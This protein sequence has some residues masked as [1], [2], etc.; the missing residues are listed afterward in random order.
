MQAASTRIATELR[1]RITAGELSPG[2]RVPST[3]QIVTDWGVAMATASK[4]LAILRQDGLVEAL[5]GFGTV[6]AGKRAAPGRSGPGDLT[7]ERIVRAA[8]LIADLEGLGA[9]SMRRV[10]TELSVATMSLYRHIAN[11]DKL[12]E[13]MADTIFSDHPLPARPRG[14]WRAQLESVMRL[15]WSLYR[16]HPWLAQTIS[17]ARPQFLPNLVAHAEWSLRA[18]APFDLPTDVLLHTHI[19]VFSFVRATALSNE[20]ELEA[21]RDTGLTGDEWMDRQDEAGEAIHATGRF[22]HL[23]ALVDRDEFE[24]DFDALFEFGMRSLLDG[25]A[26]SVRS[27][28]SRSGTRKSPPPPRLR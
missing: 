5:P 3:R 20:S 18:L 12:T 11:R 17:I 28:G 9:V 8:I 22:P 26:V 6:V 16:K 27:A 2:D 10:A 4:A 24:L 19:T 23:A 15:Q 21:R 13:L 25:I 1:R 7:A 14:D